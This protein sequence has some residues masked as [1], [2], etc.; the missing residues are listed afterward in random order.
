MS[1][2]ILFVSAWFF[3]LKVY[4]PSKYLRVFL[5]YYKCFFYVFLTITQQIKTFLLKLMI[6]DAGYQLL[7]FI[8]SLS[9][10]VP[11]SESERI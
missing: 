3:Y 7:A 8:L 11:L 5:N 2:F 4:F 1:I 9:Q 6:E 10:A